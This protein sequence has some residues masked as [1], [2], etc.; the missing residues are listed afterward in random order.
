[1]LSAT[2]FA[3]YKYIGERMSLANLL[4]TNKCV[5]G[6]IITDQYAVYKWSGSK[7]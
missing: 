7:A 6:Q 1:M 4:A 3:E 2:L 5:G